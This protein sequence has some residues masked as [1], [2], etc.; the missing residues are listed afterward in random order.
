MLNISISVSIKILKWEKWKS[1]LIATIV[2]PQ[3]CKLSQRIAQENVYVR[4]SNET[5]YYYNKNKCPENAKTLK[6]CKSDSV[7][8]TQENVGLLQL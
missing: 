3:E 4:N 8:N 5:I 1:Q 6:F 2:G 7:R